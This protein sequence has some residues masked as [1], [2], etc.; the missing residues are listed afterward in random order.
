M[1]FV[2]HVRLMSFHA[3]KESEYAK[4]KTRPR[5]ASVVNGMGFCIIYN[6]FAHQL[7]A[8]K[9]TWY[10]LIVAQWSFKLRL[11]AP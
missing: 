11:S 10:K 4:K 8:G 1:P 3:V 5:L 9:P 7:P 2:A 6:P